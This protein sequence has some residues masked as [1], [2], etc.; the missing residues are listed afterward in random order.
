MIGTTNIRLTLWT[1]TR[2]IM[3]SIFL[4][5][6]KTKHLWPSAF[7]LSNKATRK[8]IFPDSWMSTASETPP[9]TP[10]LESSLFSLSASSR[11]I[12]LS[13]KILVTTILQDTN[14]YSLY[15]SYKDYCTRQNRATIAPCILCNT[16]HFHPSLAWSMPLM[17]KVLDDH[18]FSLEH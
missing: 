8:T 12:I 13:I 5:W 2:W 7:R 3:S 17:I 14:N 10:W 9:A 15:H 16:L 18:I 11:S 1:M 4:D 6:L